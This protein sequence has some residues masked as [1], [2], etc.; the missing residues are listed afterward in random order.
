[1]D[2]IKKVLRQLLKD[3]KMANDI[4]AALERQTAKMSDKD[5]ME[6]R[7]AAQKIAL[8]V[9]REVFKNQKP[10]VPKKKTIIVPD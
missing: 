10:P 1:M 7:M 6:A 9:A 3:K 4:S 8:E 2:P 5:E